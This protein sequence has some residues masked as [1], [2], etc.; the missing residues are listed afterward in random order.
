MSWII[1]IVSVETILL[2]AIKRLYIQS[3]T[4]HLVAVQN[5]LS[6][7]LLPGNIWIYG[8]KINYKNL[9]DRFSDWAK[10][11]L[12]FKT[13]ENKHRKLVTPHGQN[14]TT[15]WIRF[16]LIKIK[17]KPIFLIDWCGQ[18]CH[19]LNSHSSLVMLRRQ[20]WSFSMNHCSSGGMHDGRGIQN[21]DVGIMKTWQDNPS[22]RDVL[23]SG[24][25]GHVD[26]FDAVTGTGQGN[27]CV[28]QSFQS[29]STASCVYYYLHFMV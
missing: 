18:N 19:V 27:R 14:T 26:R 28:C 6:G 21:I 22:L 9:S 16:S 12:D 8:A 15:H 25:L 24:Q 20:C 7:P 10:L 23:L 3:V 4:G 11:I 1:Y 17:I 13:T 5:G 2:K 29:S